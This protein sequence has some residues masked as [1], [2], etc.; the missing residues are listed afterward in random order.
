MRKLIFIFFILGSI[1]Q[2]FAVNMTVHLSSGQV[3]TIALDQDSRIYFSDPEMDVTRLVSPA[4]AATNVA[5]DPIFSWQYVSGSEMEFVL[6]ATSDFHDTLVHLEN[7][8][9]NAIQT[10]T[11]LQLGTQY[12]W[13]VRIHGKEL[14]TAPWYFTTYSPELPGKINSFALLTADTPG[15]VQLK[16]ADPAEIDSFLIVYSESGIEFIDSVYCDTTDMVIEGL[17]GDT[18][19]YVK[20]AGVNG[21]GT[22]PLSEMLAVST[23]PSDTCVLI[24]NGFDRTTAGNS[25]DFIRQ[26]AAAVINS[27]YSLVSATNEALS[28]E[29]FD[30]ARYSIMI[31]ILGEESTADETFSDLEQDIV[32]SFLKNGGNLFVSGAEIAWDLDYRG[33]SSDKAFC[34]NFLHMGYAQD[35]PNNTSGTYYRVNPVSALMFSDPGSFYFDNGSH[36]TYNVRYPDVVTPLNDAVKFLNYHGCSAGAAGIMF[37]GMFPGG[38][39]E[40]KIMFLGFPFETVYPEATRFILMDNFFKFVQ[41]GLD[42]G[43]DSSIPTVHRLYQNYPNPFNPSTTISYQLSGPS[44][45]KLTIIDL[46]GREIETLVNKTQSAGRYEII[47]DAGHIATGVYVCVL[48]VDNIIKGSHKMLLV[49]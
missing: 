35:A 29:I 33:S 27:G 25:H 22:G 7:I 4:N 3:D 42:V 43:I 47:W 23:A 37:E 13:K 12:F 5:L 2:G 14:W 26:H 45:V 36:G 21:A 20:I 19:L 24:I 44:K 40:G 31:Y 17:P 41:N 9:T 11:Q 10:G 46:N 49:K 6:S 8:D 1:A 18:S 16:V 38:S 32:E 39:A 28:D 15:K 34:H 30:L 48:K